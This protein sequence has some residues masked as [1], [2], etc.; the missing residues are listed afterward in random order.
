MKK[1][2]ES[3]SIEALKIKQILNSKGIE[4]FEDYNHSLNDKTSIISA[5]GNP[6]IILNVNKVD[7]LSAQKLLTE[8]YLNENIKNIDLFKQFEQIKYIHLL[9]KNQSTGSPK[10]FAKKLNISQKQMH[11]KLNFLKNLNAIIKYCKKNETFYYKK[12]FELLF[13]FSLLSIS[14]ENIFELYCSSE[15]EIQIINRNK[16]ELV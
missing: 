6:L 5:G 14:N 12:P 11:I 2:S 3:S 4:V 9:I 16:S 1:I 15:D 8:Q 13:Q 10:I 7:Y